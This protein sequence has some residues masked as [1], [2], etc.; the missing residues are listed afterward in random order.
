MTRDHR[1]ALDSVQGESSTENCL[2]CAHACTDKSCGGQRSG[3]PPS[4]VFWD[5][6]NRWTLTA[7]EIHREPPPLCWECLALSK[8]MLELN[9][10][11]M[12]MSQALYLLS[13]TPYPELIFYK[14]WASSWNRRN[15]P[16]LS[17]SA[18]PD[19][20]LRFL[21]YMAVTFKY[22]VYPSRQS[23]RNSEWLN[24]ASSYFH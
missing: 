3:R 11:L 14:V 22:W 8:W 1:R 2:V 18:A 21:S 12:L 17:T 24:V 20:D 6:V 9:S 15:I 19:L 5:R 23:L 10:G 16:S 7:P 13:H 4:T